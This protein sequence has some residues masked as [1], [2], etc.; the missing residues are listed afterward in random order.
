MLAW[1]IRIH[2]PARVVDDGS[3]WPVDSDRV[4]Q[5]AVVSHFPAR[6]KKRKMNCRNGGVIVCCFAFRGAVCYK[7]GPDSDDADQASAT[8]PLD[9]SRYNLRLYY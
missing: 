6:Q 2:R 3:L 4:H 8:A 9:I 5:V 7:P 1:R